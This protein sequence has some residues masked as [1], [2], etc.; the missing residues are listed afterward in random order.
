[1]VQGK[2][3][4]VAVGFRQRSREAAAHGIGA[5][6]HDRDARGI[7]QESAYGERRL[8]DQHVRREPDQLPREW[9][10]FRKVPIEVAKRVANVLPLD[11]AKP[12]HS[13]N[14]VSNEVRVFRIQDVENADRGQRRGEGAR[15]KRDER[16]G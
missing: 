16:Q 15:C 5:G 6:T 7:P 11:V 1:M 10:D 14:E 4:D 8:R 12:L 2:A 3:G 13:G 9:V